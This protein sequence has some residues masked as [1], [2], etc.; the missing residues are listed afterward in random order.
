[1]K[2]IILVCS[3]CMAVMGLVSCGDLIETSD[4]G[5][6]DGLWHLT[7][8]D[9]LETGRGADMAE[10]RKYLA[11]QGSILELHDADESEKYM[12]RFSHADGKLA[13]SDARRNDRRHGD[14]EVTDVAVLT[15]YG[16][17]RLSETFKVENLTG[18][19]LVLVSSTLRLIYRKF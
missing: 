10:D 7:R 12:F 15:P 17:N 8:I 18:S 6:L 3:L 19:R 11:V 5:R 9:T 16:I 2:K 1:M 14:P 13:L 4:N